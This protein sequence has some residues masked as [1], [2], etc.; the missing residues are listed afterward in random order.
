M[1]GGKVLTVQFTSASA[2]TGGFWKPPVG[3]KRG[4]NLVTGGGVFIAEVTVESAGLGTDAP[5][6]FRLVEVDPADHY[7]TV[8]LHPAGEV[9]GSAHRDPAHDDAVEHRP[10]TPPVAAA[11]LP[12]AGRRAFGHRRGRPALAVAGR[13]RPAAPVSAGPVPSEISISAARPSRGTVSLVS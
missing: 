8:K 9:S 1:P 3:T 5:L 10:G 2:N 13:P 6:E 4:Y 12:S 11:L 7:Q